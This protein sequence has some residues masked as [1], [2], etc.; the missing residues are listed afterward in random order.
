MTFLNKCITLNKKQALLCSLLCIVSLTAGAA[1]TGP[2]GWNMVSEESGVTVSTRTVANHDINEIR[3]KTKLKASVNQLVALF[4]DV[5]KCGL[6]A[7]NCGSAK[8]LNKQSDSEFNLYRM[9]T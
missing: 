3:A 7:E 1:N 2:E 5:D 6:W 9:K 8:I 4:M